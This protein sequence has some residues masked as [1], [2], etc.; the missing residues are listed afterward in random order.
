MY[1]CE[2]HNMFEAA[3]KALGS[4]V[5]YNDV[6]VETDPHHL[7]DRYKTFLVSHGDCT[8]AI[9]EQANNGKLSRLYYWLEAHAKD[10]GFEVRG[11]YI[12]Q[13]IIGRIGDDPAIH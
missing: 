3:E 4:Q 8:A 9:I 6:P 7:Y 11:S 5:Y 2:A 13:V 12:S 1:Q 10:Y